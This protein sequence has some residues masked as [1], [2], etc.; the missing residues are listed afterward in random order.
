MKCTVVLATRVGVK[1]NH[2]GGQSEQGNR[3]TAESATELV[4]PGRYGGKGSVVVGFPFLVKAACSRLQRLGCRS[5]DGSCWPT[6][7]S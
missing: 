3:S 2:A 4:R 1:Q 6:N 7:G 5:V